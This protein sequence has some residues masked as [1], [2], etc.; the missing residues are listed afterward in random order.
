M[1]TCGTPIGRTCTRF[2]A[3]MFSKVRCQNCYK[4]KEMHSEDALE[5]G[6]VR[7]LAPL[8]FLHFLLNGILLQIRA[9]SLFFSLGDWALFVQDLYLFY[10]TWKLGFQ[11]RKT[12]N[13]P[14]KF[15][16]LPASNSHSMFT[17]SSSSVIPRRRTRSKRPSS[18]PIPSNNNSNKQIVLPLHK[19]KGADN[20]CG[21]A[22]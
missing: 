17:K 19:R 13:Y 2:Q 4:T 12:P 8:F 5:Q 6:K 9:L 7:W 21:L 11:L 16:F 18:S 14:K 10:H 15:K 3:N 1:L 20:E 22:I